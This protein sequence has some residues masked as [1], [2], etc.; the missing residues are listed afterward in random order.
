MICSSLYRFTNVE[1][2]MFRVLLPLLGMVG[3]AL[4]GSVVYAQEIHLRASAKIT[5][6]L[7]KLGDVAEIHG[8]SA[9]DQRA[10]HDLVLQ[11]YSPE[12]ATMSAHEIREELAAAGWN[13]LHWEVTGAPRIQL[14]Q[15]DNRSSAS[16]QQ[17]KLAAV[18]G[19]I[20]TQ[21]R[22]SALDHVPGAG[23][24]TTH[25]SSQRTGVVQAQWVEEAGEQGVPFGTPT[26]AHLRRPAITSSV[27]AFRQ[28]MSRGQIVTEQDLE[29]VVLNRAAPSNS[30]REASSIIGQVVRTSVQAG[31][32][33][34]STYLEPVKHVQRGKEVRLLSRVG[35]IEV[36]TTARSLADGTLGQTVSIESLDRQRQYQ[37]QVVGFNTVQVVSNQ[38][39]QDGAI[40]A[41]FTP[42]TDGRNNNL[43]RAN[44]NPRLGQ[45][46]RPPRNT[47]R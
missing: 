14:Q 18:H 25:P 19:A 3:W 31:R 46:N 24:A 6:S 37:G 20:D 30:V 1:R 36:S 38:E 26:P 32:P 10:L 21:T 13:L 16:N 5:G 47:L 2:T 9:E 43:V 27:W 34:L 23:F 41:Q 11:P 45:G 28:D 7:V 22:R 40:V 42:P 39:T 35:P 4:C 17:R 8:G 15:A 29:E 44:Q 33:I 12:Q